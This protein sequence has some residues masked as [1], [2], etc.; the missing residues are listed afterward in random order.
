M[1]TCNGRAY[2][3]L[4]SD[5]PFVDYALVALAISPLEGILAAESDEKEGLN[6]RVKFAKFSAI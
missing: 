5:E 1:A 3:E 6:D 2:S 4:N